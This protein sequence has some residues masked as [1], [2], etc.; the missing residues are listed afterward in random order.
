MR[1]AK[2]LELQLDRLLSEYIT[3]D[4]PECFCRCGKKATEP[5]HIYPRRI[6]ILR[7]DL[8]NVIPICR[9]CHTQVHSTGSGKELRERYIP[10]MFGTDWESYIL[11]QRKKV[12]D[13]TVKD[14]AEMVEKFKNLIG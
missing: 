10:V 13:Y 3:Q 5:H 14:L 7:W 4:N 8:R 1:T 12:A 9:T 2:N 6:K 11:E